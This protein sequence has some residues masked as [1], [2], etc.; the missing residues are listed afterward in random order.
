[1]AG[2]HVWI[3]GGR[4]VIGAD[5]HTPDEAEAIGSKLAELI[6]AAAAEARH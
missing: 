3:S 1:V 6:T 2:I 4:V 5:S